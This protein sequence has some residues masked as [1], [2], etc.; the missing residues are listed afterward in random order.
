MN[1]PLYPAKIVLA[2]L[3]PLAAGLCLG[4]LALA[5]FEDAE[6]AGDVLATKAV[7]PAVLFERLERRA[8]T[9]A[10]NLRAYAKS[11]EKPFLDAAKRE[12][13][14]AMET[15]HDLRPVGAI[16][17][18]D[19][20]TSNDRPQTSNFSAASALRD[21]KARPVFEA[22]LMDRA[23]S[24]LDAYKEQAELFVAACGTLASLRKG[25]DA[26]AGAYAASVDQAEVVARGKLDLG[27]SVLYPPLEKVRLRRRQYDILEQSAALGRKAFNAVRQAG[28]DGKPFSM[29]DVSKYFRAIRGSLDQYEAT[30]LVEEADNLAAMREAASKY[31]SRT[32]ALLGGWTEALDAEGKLLGGE[33]ALMET[34]SAM[35]SRSLEKSDAL[36]RG[37]ASNLV[38][39]RRMARGAMLVLALFGVIWIVLAVTALSG[40][41]VKCARYA[42]ELADEDEKTPLSPLPPGGRGEIGGLAGA[43][44]KIAERLGRS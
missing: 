32:Q 33:K 3:V 9:T 28:L 4:W 2:L 42:R 23:A 26:A 35:A 5:R 38:W 20:E 36:A 19:N 34:V 7:A 21:P 14:A 17:L 40:P 6:L 24:Q 18:A 22:P 27:L 16:A 8:L 30:G 41:V 25:F 44:R 11:G 1:L 29:N 12:L 37:L 31:E 15:L 43:L 10:Y 13:A 39:S